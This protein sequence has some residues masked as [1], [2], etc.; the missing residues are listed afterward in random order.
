MDPSDNIQTKIWYMPKQKLWLTAGKDFKLRHWAVYLNKP[1]NCL[2]TLELHTDLI[3]DCVE[4]DNPV[5][6][7]TC[8]LDRTIVLFD[9]EHREYLRTIKQGHEK[10]IRHLRY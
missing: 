7:A 3:T 8:S 2:Q 4:V 5:C 10:G 1:G 6:I 9:V